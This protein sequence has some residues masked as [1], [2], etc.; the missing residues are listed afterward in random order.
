MRFHAAVL[1]LLLTTPGAVAQEIPERTAL[2]VTADDGAEIDIE[3][4]HETLY[5]PEA[6][7]LFA[8]PTMAAVGDGGRIF[9]SDFQD[10]HVAALHPDGRED[11]II[12]GPGQGPGEFEDAWAVA[13]VPGGDLYVWDRW[14]QQVHRFSQE[15]DYRH[16]LAMPTEI[17]GIDPKSF[18]GLGPQKLL[19]AGVVPKAAN[20]GYAVHLLDLHTVEPGRQEFRLRGQLAAT[21][22]VSPLIYQFVSGGTAY[23]DVDGAIPYAQGSPYMLSRYSPTGELDW[24]LEHP[25]TFPH[26]SEFSTVT[27]EGGGAARRA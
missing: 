8:Q 26:W 20:D 18:V 19:V 4:S 25:E 13:V 11:F 7:T 3:F 15:G 6:S 5:D 2:R 10:K 21:M 22:P 9:I 16:S 1:L 24:R 14:T 27:P 23:L 12:G 17:S